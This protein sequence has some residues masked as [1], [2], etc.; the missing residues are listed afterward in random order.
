MIKAVIFDMD[1]LLVDSEPFWRA[2][3]RRVLRTVGIDP[4][5]EQMHQSM[6]R[7]INEVIEHWY[8]LHP[9]EGPSIE[10]ITEQVVDEVINQIQQNGK[11]LPGVHQVIKML[12][13]KGLP[14][15]IASSSPMKLI[16]STVDALEL[17]QYFDHI[18]S[19]EHEKYGKPNPGVFI[20]TAELLGFDPHYCLVFED[21][22]SGVLAAKAARM[23]CVAV[24][25]AKVSNNS[26]ILTADLVIDSLEDFGEAQLLK[27]QV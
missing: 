12:K 16:D 20:K 14:M 4:T 19:A 17:R 8:R 27:F 23:Q 9:W 1:G 2:A 6:G 26:F 24:P 13:Q 11:L 25:Q 22:P 15:A 3:E 18:Y 21:A 7:P 10:E 5:D